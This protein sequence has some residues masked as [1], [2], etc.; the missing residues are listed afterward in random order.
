[1]RAY[2]DAVAAG[3]H[4]WTSEEML[5]RVEAALP[6]YEPGHGWGYSN[7]GYLMVGELIETA[8]EKP[9]SAALDSLAFEPLGISGVVVAQEPADLDTTAW[10]NA[11][12]YH[13][14]LGL[15]MGC[16]SDRQWPLCCFCTAF[17]QASSYRPTCWPQC[18][19]PTRSEE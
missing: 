1:M 2:H 6:T 11:R 15:S 8:A 3:E 18:T 4:P 7:V 14:R 16:W 12:G 9:L 5:H 17:L 10:G 19:T 13:P